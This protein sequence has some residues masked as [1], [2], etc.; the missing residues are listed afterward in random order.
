MQAGARRAVRQGPGGHRFRGGPDRHAHR[1]DQRAHRPPARPLEGPPL[2]SRPAHARRPPAPVPQLPAEEGPRG[3]PVADPRAGPPP[4]SVLAPGTPAP[5]FTLK[6]EDL[7]D[8]TRADLEGRTTVLVFYPNS[9][10]PVCTDQL[11]IY[12]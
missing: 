3:L 2:A 9:F 1:A 4:V 8:F 11:N 5:E 6:T 12:D 10:S 7:E